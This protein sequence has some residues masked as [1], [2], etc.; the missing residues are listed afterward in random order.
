VH[1]FLSGRLPFLG[2]SA[3][4]DATL[5]A[6]P[7]EPVRSFESLYAADRRAREVAAEQVAVRA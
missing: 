5:D 3:V 7:A 4:I 2:I 1:A 6:L